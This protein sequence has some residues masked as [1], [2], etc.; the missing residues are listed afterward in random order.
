VTSTPLLTPAQLDDLARGRS[1]GGVDHRPLLEVQQAHL[2][3]VRTLRR[4]YYRWGDLVG[5][6]GLVLFPVSMLGI[7]G[8]SA[9]ERTPPF[10]TRPVLATVLCVA[11]LAPGVPGLP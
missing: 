2:A 8:R 9:D 10:V 3:R 7:L 6:P 1:G 5:F 4:E 11:G